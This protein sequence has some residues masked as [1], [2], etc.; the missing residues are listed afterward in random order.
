M[1]NTILRPDFIR[2]QFNGADNQF[3][4]P[5]EIIS[6]TLTESFDS[7]S[8]ISMGSACSSKFLVTLVVPEILEEGRSRVPY[9]DSYLIPYGCFADGAC[10]D[11]PL[12]KFYVNEVSKNSDG[13][14]LTLEC[15]DSFCK[16]DKEYSLEL[17]EGQSMSVGDAI[18]K[19]SQELDFDVDFDFSYYENLRIS[20]NCSSTAR[21]LISHIAGLMG[22]NARFDRN[23]CLTF[24]WYKTSFDKASPLT[25]G[26][27]SIYRGQFALLQE[28][29]IL[30]SAVFSGTKDDIIGENLIGNE[31]KSIAFENPY[32]TDEY[33]SD[34]LD[35]MKGL[36]FRPCTLKYRGDLNI[37]AGMLI[38][39][40]RDNTIVPVC[41]MEQITVFNGGMSSEIFCYAGE[42]NREVFQST[43]VAGKLS[44][45][46][47]SRLASLVAMKKNITESRGGVFEIIDADNDGVQDGFVLKD[48]SGS[49]NYILANKE[50][51]ILMQRTDDGAYIG[52]TAVDF[53]GINTEALNADDIR[54]KC[55]TISGHSLDDVF[56]IAEDTSGNNKGIVLTIGASGSNFVLQQSSNNMS[57]CNKE[58]NLP[59]LS[60]N[61]GAISMGL[62]TIYLN[63]EGDVVFSTGGK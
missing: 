13:K 21:Q 37:E 59:Q 38:N 8:G 30:I 5:S 33:L 31:G 28:E 56:S 34:I 50:G 20:K 36:A 15:Y 7:S 9:A 62:L 17:T 18:E 40:E 4:A 63:S 46:N 25:I 23:G 55:L 1:S 41:V 16:L 11:M 27:D 49:G 29:D 35:N 12:G 24:D 14:M 26:E 2:L 45:K 51:I 47:E 39:V 32:M 57:F 10:E 52:K 44:P 6:A 19:M 48:G 3:S 43:F 22:M 53:K 54:A 61:P 42:G 58:T 60:I